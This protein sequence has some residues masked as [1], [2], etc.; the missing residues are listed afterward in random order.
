MTSQSE[1]S[2]KGKAPVS[3]PS[4]EGGLDDL[5]TTLRPIYEKFLVDLRLTQ[6]ME[7]FESEKLMKAVLEYAEGTGVPCPP[8]SHSYESLLVGYSYA[9]VRIMRPLITSMHKTSWD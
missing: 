1:I 6:P 9:D 3:P 4:S 7:R 8:N 5:A 2:I